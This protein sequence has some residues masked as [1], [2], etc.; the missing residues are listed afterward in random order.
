[1]PQMPQMPQ[2]P[3]KGVP[4]PA[5]VDKMMSGLG[6]FPRRRSSSLSRPVAPDPAVFVAPRDLPPGCDGGLLPDDVLPLDPSARKAY[7]ITM[8]GPLLRATVAPDTFSHT[9]AA[10]TP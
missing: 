2:M 6:G 9:R 10:S 1:M 7:S 4:P 5:Q 3:G 8:R